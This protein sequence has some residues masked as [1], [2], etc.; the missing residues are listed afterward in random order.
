MTIRIQRNECQT[1]YR[2]VQVLFQLHAI[3]VPTLALR[4]GSST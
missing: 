2:L 1:E 4:S 3:A